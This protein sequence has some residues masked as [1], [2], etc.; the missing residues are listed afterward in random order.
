MNE[1]YIAMGIGM[2]IFF[3]IIYILGRLFA[4]AFDKERYKRVDVNDFNKKVRVIERDI[5]ERGKRKVEID[6]VL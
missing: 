2:L 4:S 3:F 6:R 1:E 5:K